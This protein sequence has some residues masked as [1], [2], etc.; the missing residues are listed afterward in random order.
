MQ[1]PSGPLSPADYI[2]PFI[3]KP[4]YDEPPQMTESVDHLP[5]APWNVQPP[6]SL[7]PPHLPSTTKGNSSLSKTKLFGVVL[8]IQVG[9]RWLCL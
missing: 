4:T 5:P 2:N 1:I 9:M 7:L 8:L 6:S 3:R